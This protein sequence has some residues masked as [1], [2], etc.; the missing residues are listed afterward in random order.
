VKYEELRKIRASLPQ[1]GQ[2]PA[3]MWAALAPRD[4]TY[5]GLLGC[6]SGPRANN[7]VEYGQFLQALRRDG[8]PPVCGFNTVYKA[9]RYYRERILT[10]IA[11]RARLPSRKGQRSWS[12]VTV[13]S[14]SRGCC[15]RT[16]DI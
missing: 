3:L 12:T 13:P 6:T 16:S 11:H 2:V 1:R 14:K 5:V 8:K 9:K 10:R 7:S 15:R 4:P